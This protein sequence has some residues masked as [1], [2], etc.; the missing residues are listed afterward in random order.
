MADKIYPVQLSGAQP[1]DVHEY[2]RFFTGTWTE[3]GLATASSDWCD[4]GA[5]C[6]LAIELVVAALEG[7]SPTLDA[8]VETTHDPAVDSTGRTAITLAQFTAAGTKRGEAA[9]NRWVRIKRTYGGTVT[10]ATA[11]ATVTFN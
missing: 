3:T 6:T 10:T 8:I 5:P 4:L 9:V 7:T 2:R 11:T 1:Q